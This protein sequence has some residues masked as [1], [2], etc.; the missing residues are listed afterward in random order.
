[1]NIDEL[2]MVRESI[3]LGPF[4]TEIIEGCVKPLPGSTLYVM[5]TLLKA[6]G[7][8]RETKPLPLGLHV[9]HAYTRLKNGSV[10]VSLVVRNVSD[11]QIFLKKG[12]LVVRVVSTMLVS[13]AELSPEME[14]TLG[15]ESRPE[16]LSVA[17]RQEKLLEKLNLDGLAH[18]SPENAVAVRELVLAYHDVFM[19]E[20]NELGC[21]SAIEHE[22][23]IENEEPFKEQFRHIPPPLLEEVHASLRDMLEAGAIHPSQ[24]PWCNVAVLVQKKD[25]TLHFCVDFRHLNACMKKDS[26]PL[27]WIQEALESIVG[28]AHFSSMD[29]KSGFWQIKMAPGSQQYMAFTMGN[30]GFYKFTC[31]PFG[32]CN[33][34]A[35]FQHLMQNTLGELNLTYCVIYLDDVIVFSRMEE[36]HLEWLH[37][38]LERFCKFNLK[39]KPLKCSFFQSGIMYL[40]H[41][42]LWRGILPS[43]ENVWAVQE[44]PMPETYTQVHAFC[45]LAEHYRRFIKGFANIAGPLYN[46]LGKE[47]KWI[48]PLMP[49]R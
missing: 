37:V 11:S 8:Q 39:L 45:G 18:W 41:H 12:L 31:M 2:V 34:P 29:F 14:A 17:V 9:L 25:G 46:V 38:V 28:S 13:P 7:Q 20:S 10:R 40:A 15:K 33:A 5:I 16:P 26:Y 4:Q 22:I 19:L 44:F 35:M 32:L 3:H 24:S 6:E 49:R 30:L 48:C 23:R 47:V 36:E 1:M 42:V 43:Q 21:T 27:P